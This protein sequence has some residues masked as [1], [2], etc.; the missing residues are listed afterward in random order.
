M[1][2]FILLTALIVFWGIA[3]A[4]SEAVPKEYEK[5]TNPVKATEESIAAGEQIFEQRCATCH[6]ADGKGVLQGMPDLTDHPMMSEMSEGDVF[7]KISEGVPGTGMPPWK[8]ALT[9]EERWHLVNYINTLHHGEEEEAHIDTQSAEA[10]PQEFH[11]AAPK[12]G[13]CGPTAL[14][15]IGTIPLLIAGRRFF[16]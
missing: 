6:G 9:E 1:K 7:H 12:K 5:A 10:K 8:D 2:F 15:L 4:H 3:Y 11:A 14:L 13:V 16:N